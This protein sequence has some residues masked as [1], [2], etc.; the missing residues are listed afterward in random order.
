MAA[1]TK[2]RCGADAQ[3]P[4]PLAA[5]FNPSFGDLMNTLVQPRHAKL[6][7]IGK[8]QNWTLAALRVAPTQG[9]TVRHRQIEAGVRRP[10]RT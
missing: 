5:P 9:R 1:I 8:E 2:V 4:R 3:T 7:L 6:G 10:T